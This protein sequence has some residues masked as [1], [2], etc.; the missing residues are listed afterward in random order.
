MP[1]WS[2]AQRI[3]VLQSCVASAE[4]ALEGFA[5]QDGEGVVHSAHVAAQKSLGSL[6]GW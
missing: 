2:E 4:L 3:A 5:R 6:Q 1:L